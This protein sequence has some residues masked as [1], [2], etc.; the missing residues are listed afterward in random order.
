MYFI[1]KCEDE[2]VLCELNEEI[3]VYV[4]YIAYGEN[5]TELQKE[6]DLIFEKGAIDV[7][8][9][10][11]AWYIGIELHIINKNNQLKS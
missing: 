7:S 8:S 6:C 2:F 3:G 5:L 11:I 9:L 1:E 4:P 10:E